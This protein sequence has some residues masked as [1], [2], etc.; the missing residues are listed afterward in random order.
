MDNEEL[1]KRAPL[2]D[3]SQL[4]DPEFLAVCRHVREQRELTPHDEVS[5]ELAEKYDAVNR[6][7]LRRAGLAWQRG[8]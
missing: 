1:P 2:T 3:L 7:F 5:R 8:N 4:D 6:E